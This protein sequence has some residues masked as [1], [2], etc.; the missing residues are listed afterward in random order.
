[1]LTALL[2]S[3]RGFVGSNGLQSRDVPP[4]R[5][6]IRMVLAHQGGWDEM[7][8]VIVPLLLI[9][10]LLRVANRRANR[11]AEIH[12]RAMAPPEEE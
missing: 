5:T 6:I 1:M 10:A 4:D 3:Y 12:R 8:L 7:L 2:V 9:G 11:L